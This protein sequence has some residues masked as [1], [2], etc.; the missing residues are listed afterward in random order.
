M[1][2]QNSPDP[3]ITALDQSRQAQKITHRILWG[4]ALLFALFISGFVAN[5][6]IWS[7]IGTFVVAFVAQVAVSIYRVS[8]IPV[9]ILLLIYCLVDHYFS[10]HGE[11]NQKRLLIQYAGL[12]I[13]TGMF[14]QAT[15]HLIR[16]VSQLKRS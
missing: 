9:L 6:N 2:R 13:F 12:A 7:L 3:L 4:L 1:T 16:V 8:L 10:M 5:L 11:F 14:A 15:P